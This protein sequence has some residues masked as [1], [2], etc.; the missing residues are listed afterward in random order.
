MANKRN[1]FTQQYDLIVGEKRTY[2]IEYI[3]II[4][5]LYISCMIFLFKCSIFEYEI[6]VSPN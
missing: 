4:H 2:N 5:A 3:Y 1:N 6:R